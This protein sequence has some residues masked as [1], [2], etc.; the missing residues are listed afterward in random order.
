MLDTSQSLAKYMY[1][2]SLNFLNYIFYTYAV[3]AG[4]NYSTSDFGFNI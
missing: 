4:Y 3:P 1:L 2:D